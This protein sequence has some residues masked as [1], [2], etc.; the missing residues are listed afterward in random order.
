VFTLPK[1]ITEKALDSMKEAILPN[2][3][4]TKLGRIDDLKNPEKTEKQI[5]DL[6]KEIQNL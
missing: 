6:C 4:L 1:E 5:I 3:P 2:I